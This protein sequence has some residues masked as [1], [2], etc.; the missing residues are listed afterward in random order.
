MGDEHNKISHGND[1]NSTTQLT[2]PPLPQEDNIFSHAATAW[3][4]TAETKL[5]ARGFLTII[6]E[7][8]ELPTPAQEIID[9]PLLPVPAGTTLS[10]KDRQWRITIEIENKRNAM[11]RE[12]ILTR[13]GR[14]CTQPY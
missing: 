13:P 10:L 4:E 7:P 8:A 5:T 6:A 12:K 9:T 3:I 1:A 2:L 14:S 11:K